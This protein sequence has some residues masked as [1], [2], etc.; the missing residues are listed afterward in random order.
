MALVCARQDANGISQSSDIGCR[1]LICL[2]WMPT[3]YAQ[4]FGLDVGHSAALSILPWGLNIVATNIA[5]YL[6]D[7]VCAHIFIIFIFS[8]ICLF[9]T[10]VAATRPD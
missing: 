8:G 6:G 5:G 10:A 9:K 4:E 1:P 2:S 7:K 3:Y